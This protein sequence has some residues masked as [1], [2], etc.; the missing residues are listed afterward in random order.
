MIA[1]MAQRRL[2]L[3]ADPDLLAGF[4]PASALEEA[5]PQMRRQRDDVELTHIERVSA[6]S[7]G[8]IVLMAPSVGDEGIDE[9]AAVLRDLLGI[10]AGRFELVPEVIETVR[11][12][13]GRG[14][15]CP[16]CP[17]AD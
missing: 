2:R 5:R 3:W 1:G 8:V 12:F 4:D 6:D 10:G 11:G 16:H 13:G 15:T 17:W 9:L 7:I 14:R